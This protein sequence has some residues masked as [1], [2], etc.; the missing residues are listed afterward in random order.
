MKK[1]ALTLFMVFFT[2]MVFPQKAMIDT[3]GS[4]SRFT[5]DFTCMPEY[6]YSQIP[7][8]LNSGV[9]G[10]IGYVYSKVAEDYMATGPFNTMKF[11]GY[12]VLYPV[13][14]FLIEVYDGVPGQA[15]TQVI[16]TFNVNLTPVATT[17]YSATG[18]QVYEFTVE[19]GTNITQLNGWISISRT[20]LPYVDAFRWACYIDSGSNCL[21]YDTGASNWIFNTALPAFCLGTAA[22]IPVSNWALFIG[23]GLILAFTIIRFRKAS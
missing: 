12:R 22:E 5:H 16:H 23:L 14:S 9:F 3:P 19:F 10:D 4:A 13:E 18:Y 6:V 20:T 7:A 1:I 8:D 2:L 11:W 21:S 17:Y 15:G